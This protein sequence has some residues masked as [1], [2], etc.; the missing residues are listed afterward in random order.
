M[1][2]RSHAC[3]ECGKTFATSSG[4]KQHTHIHSS[5]K[6]FQCEVCY[7][8][9]TQFSN[10]C[11]H[12]RMH[13][14]C[15]MQIK[16]GKCGQSFSTVAALSKHKR[17]CDST[18]SLPPHTNR[19][20]PLAVTGLQSS[21]TMNTPPN[22]FLMF[23]GRSPFFPHGFHHYSGLQNMFSHNTSQPQ[24]H[25]PLLFG[26]PPQSMD[27]PMEHE[28][29]D[30]VKALREHTR[31]NMSDVSSSIVL[32]KSNS[33]S[34]SPVPHHQQQNSSLLHTNNNTNHITNYNTA[35]GS[36][37]E[38][39]VVSERKRMRNSRLNNSEDAEMSFRKRKLSEEEDD[40]EKVSSSVI[41][42]NFE[43]SN[44]SFS[45]PSRKNR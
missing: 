19:E 40:S 3:L 27:I 18:G 25:F 12:R 34:P 1:G 35:K 30:Q 23:T 43:N 7:K 17:F 14:N 31:Q 38:L 29:G 22:P 32:E 11:R 13:V 20:H 45:F 33:M 21:A 16:C 39:D 36:P 9:Y 6:P 26:K 15:R 10:L 41:G 37:K 28:K 8:A 5:V 2:A 24:P 44:K 42:G 4:L